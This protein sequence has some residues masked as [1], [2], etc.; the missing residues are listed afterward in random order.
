MTLG[1][2]VSPLKN[3]EGEEI[4]IIF[5]FQDLTKMREMEE[6]LK[7]ADRLAAI[8]TLAAGMAHE[9]RNPLAS[10]SGSIEILKEEMDG[11]F[12]TS[13]SWISSSGKWVVLIP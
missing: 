11:P 6:D 7:R 9:I 2:S 8:G 13:N 3:S 1:F 12:N 5:I 10:I 4:G